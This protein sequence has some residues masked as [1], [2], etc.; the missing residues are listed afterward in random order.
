MGRPIA[1]YTDAD[2]LDLSAGRRLLEEA[3]FEVRF[4]GSRDPEH[5]ATVA[6]DAVALLVG[7]ARIDA[8][9]LH[10]LPTVRVIATLSAGYDMVDVQAAAQRGVWVA[11]IPDGAV[12]EVAVHALAMGLSLLRRLPMLD[13]HVRAGGWSTTVD[14]RLIR[15]STATFGLLGCGRIGQRTAALAS[16][17]F[18]EI[19]GYDPYV[20]EKRWPAMVRKVDLP[21]LLR[22]ADVLSLHLP[23]TAETENMV[24]AEA[25]AMIRPGALLVNVARGRLLD[26]SAVRAALD[27][28][29]LAGAA[30]DVLDHEPPAADDPLRSHPRTLVTPHSAYLSEESQRDYVTRQAA[31]VVS[32]WRTQRPNNPVQEITDEAR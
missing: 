29:R 11:N 4:I 26:S 3:G 23:L 31:N 7:Y 1:A 28:G 25:L 19:V 18:G 22:S 30:L 13:R 10:R 21:D 24:N 9:L 32:W 20:D 15:P 17:L 12:E 5:I 27:S 2:E 16:P 8:S 6:A 14:E